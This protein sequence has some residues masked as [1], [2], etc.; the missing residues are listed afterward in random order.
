MGRCQ[1]ASKFIRRGPE[2]YAA[3]TNT[4]Q[5]LKSKSDRSCGRFLVEIGKTGPIGK[6][7]CV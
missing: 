1:P 5:F 7:T 6:S 4:N 2:R 3:F